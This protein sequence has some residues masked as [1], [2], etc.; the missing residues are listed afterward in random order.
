MISTSALSSWLP[1]GKPARSRTACALRRSTGMFGRHLAVGGGRVEAEEAALADH[2]AVGVEALDADVVEVARAVDRRARV[3]LASA[4][5]G[6][7]RS[8]S[9]RTAGGSLA[10]A[11]DCAPAPPRSSPSPEPSTRVQRVAR[12]ARTRGSRGT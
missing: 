2:V 7:A 5:A 10:N 11:V 3:G 8:A 4:R 12:S 6:A 9:A 1:G